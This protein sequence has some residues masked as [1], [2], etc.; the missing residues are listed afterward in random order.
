MHPQQVDKLSN[1]NDY[2]YKLDRAGIGKNHVATYGGFYSKIFQYEDFLSFRLFESETKTTMHVF[3]DHA[4]VVIDPFGM[5]I[6]HEN[7][8]HITAIPDLHGVRISP[9]QSPS[10]EP[11]VIEILFTNIIRSCLLVDLWFNITRLSFSSYSHNMVAIHLSKLE[12]EDQ[13]LPAISNNN[14]DVLYI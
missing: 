3:A 9:R 5:K 13:F 6:S 2:F 7:A 12:E 4:G 11:T 10:Y 1:V 14:I 8:A